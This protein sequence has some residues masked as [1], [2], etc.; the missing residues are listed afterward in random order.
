[1]PVFDVDWFN[2]PMVIRKEKS[3]QENPEK[4]T[5]KEYIIY[6]LYIWNYKY[7]KCSIFGEKV[8]GS[9]KRSKEWLK[10]DWQL[11]RSIPLSNTLWGLSKIIWGLI[12]FIFGLG[13]KGISKIRKKL[14][15]PSQ[16]LA[17]SLI[18]I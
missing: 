9:T 3:N 13:L 18:H 2:Q 15:K 16:V 12:R 1:M 10:K 5:F 14:G 7:P 8:E 11:L 4:K 6:Q 17:L